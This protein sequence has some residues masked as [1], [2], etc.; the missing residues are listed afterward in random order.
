MK[1][2]VIR[3]RRRQFFSC[4]LAVLM[5]LGVCNTMP[6]NSFGWL[7]DLFALDVIYAEISTAPSTAVDNPTPYVPPTPVYYSVHYMVDGKE[8]DTSE[9][10]GNSKTVESGVTMSLMAPKKEGYIFDGWYTTADFKPQSKTT[11]L[12]VSSDT[13]VYGRWALPIKFYV[14]GQVLEDENYPAYYIP[15]TTIDKLADGPHRAGLK[16]EGWYR[17]EA[18]TQKVE[19]AAVSEKDTEGKTF[20]ARYIM[21]KDEDGK[22]EKVFSLYPKQSLSLTEELQSYMKEGDTY[23]FVSSDPKTVEVDEKGVVSWK[24]AGSAE[25]HVYRNQQY[26]F[27]VLIASKKGLSWK[28]YKATYN[29]KRYKKITLEEYTPEDGELTFQSSDKS[30]VTVGT[31]NHQTCRVM[32]RNAGKAVVTAL[33]DGKPVDTATVTVGKAIPSIRIVRLKSKAPLREEKQYQVQIEHTRGVGFLVSTKTKKALRK[34]G[35]TVGKF[36]KT[37]KNKTVLKVKVSP[38]KAKRKV[39]MAFRT[40]EKRNYKRV[41]KYIKVYVTD[42]TIV[43]SK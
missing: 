5:L 27:D 13:T 21:A 39:K 28:D 14:D 9:N 40:I 4:C 3:K 16:F 38:K 19:E 2:N 30:V 17:D 7:R 26:S 32:F 15:G 1:R 12:T 22:E 33:L 35:I 18:L 29:I 37:G 31:Q 41:K 24:S 8:V 42:K 25:I 23:S 36:I 6:E 43:F 11:T 10:G 34:R 20:Y